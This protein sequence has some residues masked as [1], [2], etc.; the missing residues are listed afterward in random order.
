MGFCFSYM[1]LKWTPIPL[2]RIAT[3][4]C[5]GILLGVY[6]FG[7]ISVTTAINI[8]C[9]SLGLFLISF[10]LEVRGKKYLVGF[11][12]FVCVFCCGYLI[13][14]ER[15]D[16]QE[17]N[18]I[19]HITEPIVAYEGLIQDHL[20]ERKNSFKTQ[21]T[22]RHVK[23]KAGWRAATG[24]VNL[25]IAK[26]TLQDNIRWGNRVL[27]SGTPNEVQ[28]PANP[29]EFDFKRFL[30]FKN[31]YHQH[32][33]QGTD[34]TWLGETRKDFF[35][36]SAQARRFFS[37]IIKQYVPGEQEK[38]I[39]LALVIGVT[40][41]IDNELE[42]AYSA[43]GAMHVL[44]VSGLHIGILY[45]IIL[46]F[47]KPLHR[48]QRGQ[49]LV[50]V[51]SLLLLWGYSFVTGLSPSVL[52]A[53][54]MFSFIAVAKPLN[55]RSNIFNTLAGSAIILLLFDPYLIMSVGF[56]LSYLAVLG[57]IWI[58]RPLYLLWESKTWIMDQV[59]QITCVSIA[60]QLTTFSL[61]LLYFHQFPTYFL[62]SNLFVIPISF[63]VL[64][65]GI[66]L[67]VVSFIAPVAKLVGWVLWS[68]VKLLNEGV[69]LTER[70][71]FSLINNIH[72]DVFQSWLIMGIV[73]G[74]IFTFQLKNIRWL[75]AALGLAVILSGARWIHQLDRL[76]ESKLIVYNIS[77]VSAVELIGQGTSVLYS[78][79]SF[80]TNSERV[81]FHIRPNRLYNLVSQS[82]YVDIQ[83]GNPDTFRVLD[84]SGKRILILHRKLNSL[85]S[86]PTCDLVI[87][88]GK[89]AWQM[90]ELL[91]DNPTVKFVLDGSWGR[92]QINWLRKQKADISRIYIVPEVG[93]YTMDLKNRL[94]KP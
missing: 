10:L 8:F 76:S 52:R 40:D 54:T 82:R 92:G 37:T 17:P 69:F 90:P 22:I 58:Q 73:T 80:M 19:L 56:Q 61:G 20:Y 62:F 81:R 48:T 30:T 18:N 16:S 36:Y 63:G 71:P 38:A 87:V 9:A 66:V 14:A 74:L 32:F 44:A 93:A 51:I 88:S 27:I 4:F 34:I 65:V 50:A 13:V 29:H 72:I 84:Y 94:N 85:S 75:Y 91:L 53:V 5:G 15:T 7:I 46:F 2:V 1:L 77:G 28:P 24:K 47:L 26:K 57:I 6:Q 67:L 79:S 42:S 64:V 35:Y 59:W 70:L 11:F 41:G 31:I 78:D 86:L 55:I 68:L 23:T 21:I 39:A 43:S 89:V 83:K 25:Y 60:A 45:A 33:V 49:W 3:V 12:G